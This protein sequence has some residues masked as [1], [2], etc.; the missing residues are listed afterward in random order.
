M[1]IL[2]IPRSGSIA[3][4]VSSHNRAGQYV[5]NRVSPVQPVGT[6]RRSAIRSAFSSASS[7]F[8]A[9]TA[10]QQDAWTSYADG[11]PITDTLGQSIKLTGHQMYVSVNTALL[12]L[13][14]DQTTTP[15]ADS[16]VLAIVPGAVSFSISTGASFA[17]TAGDG[18]GFV[19]L[20]FSRPLSAGRRFN[21]TFW[22][23]QFASDD[24]T[25]MTCTT[26][27]YAAQFG[28]PVAG[29]RIFMRLTPINQYGVTGVPAIV[30]AI[31][32]A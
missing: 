11:H 1:K 31:V 27:I 19:A 13:H 12:N 25:P 26:A 29:Q 20:S 16:S 6:G 24:S 5:R 30:S 15:P 8:A 3:G 18:N 2:D 7:G 28:T 23:Q 9:L 4:T 10:A 21:K 32:T 17:W 22:Q 14:E